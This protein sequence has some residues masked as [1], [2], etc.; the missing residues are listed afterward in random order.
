MLCEEFV[1][2]GR[3]EGKEFVYNDVSHFKYDKIASQDK[4]LSYSRGQDLS[5]IHLAKMILP[6]KKAF[7]QTNV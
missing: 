7:A 6:E 4:L 1:R 2:K 5:S 3:R